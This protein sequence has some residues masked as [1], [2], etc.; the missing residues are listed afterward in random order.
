[1]KQEAHHAMSTKAPRM[2]F[3]ALVVV[4]GLS[5]S[6]TNSGSP[7]PAATVCDGISSDIGGCT[8]ERHTFTATTCE[9]LAREWAGVL[10]P[11]VVAILNGPADPIQAESSRL[12]Q[13]VVIVTTDM[14]TKL[15][16]LGLAQTCDVPA[17]MAAAEPV[18][19]AD[20]R[21]KVGSGLYDGAPV[22]TYQ[23]WLADTKQT[24]AVIDFGESPEAS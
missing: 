20:L 16:A 21:A 17:F 22:A 14:N 23:D 6:C 3:L 15:R 18:F 2:L 9:G 5:A 10:D 7:S 4:V 12:K 24:V 11:Q 13:A 1:L 8:A 19:S